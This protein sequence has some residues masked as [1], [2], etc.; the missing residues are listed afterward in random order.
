MTISVFSA[1]DGSYGTISLNGSEKLRLNADGSATV[2]GTPVQRMLS[3]G[4]KATTSGTAIDFSPADGTGIP[5]WAK[6]ITVI[7]D[8]V[9]TNGADQ[10]CI[11]LGT[12]AGIDKTNYQGSSSY[13]NSTPS[14]VAFATGSGGVSIPLTSA[15]STRSGRYT[16]ENTS[17]N[18]WVYSGSVSEYTAG[19]VSTTTGR[20]AL[21]SPLTQIAITTVG[22]TDAFDAGSVSVIV[23]G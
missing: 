12:S 8:L 3:L 7:L 16:F 9:S 20:K 14:A 19:Y 13:I 1:A 17:G 6:R 22:G 2:G 15:S 5:S 4:T 10:V 21:S 11:S 18:V 23:E